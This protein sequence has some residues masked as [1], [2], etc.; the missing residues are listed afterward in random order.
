M[1]ERFAGIDVSKATLDVVIGPSNEHWTVNNDEKGFAEIIERLKGVN[2]VVLEATGGLQVAVT[3][4][5]LNAS[6]PVVAVNPRQIRDFAKSIGVLA[7]TDHIDAKVIAR[8]AETIR[9]QVR[10]LKDEETLQLNA[11]VVRRRQLVDIHTE[12]K[13]RLYIAPKKIKKDIEE[14][15]D[16]LKK[17]LNEIDKE[18]DRFIKNSPVWR[19][20]EKILRSV[21]GVGPILTA[22]LLCEL[23]ELG[24]LDRKKIS[25]LVGVA[26][27]N[28]DSGKFR[29]T[30][31]VWGGRTAVRAVLYM[32][33]L[34]A[35]RF[36]PAIKEFYQR[37]RSTGKKPK[38][39]ITA[40]MRKLLTILNSIVKTGNTWQFNFS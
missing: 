13:N 5:L 26:P 27:F 16:W 11:I 40:C 32:G 6:I 18:I 14:H 34:S 25:A 9:P 21:P 37:L 29:G 3:A 15:L 33:T 39:A 31:C 28:R 2:L 1:N 35:I 10:L 36:N 23:P 38:Q 20:K 24:V 12:E 8:F 17:R 7:K 22:T 4:A 30:R 19:E